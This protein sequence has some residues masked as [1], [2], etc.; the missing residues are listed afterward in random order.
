MKGAFNFPVYTDS[1]V[2]RDVFN[3]EQVKAAALPV[4]TRELLSSGDVFQS[5]I[6]GI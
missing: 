1:V 3:G 5:N 6:R 4:G 2:F